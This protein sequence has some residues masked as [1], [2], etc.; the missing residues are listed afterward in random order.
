MLDWIPEDIQKRFGSIAD[1]VHSGDYLY[2]PTEDARGIVQA[3]HT[4]GYR[5]E[6]DE[7]LIER[8]HGMR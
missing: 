3:M 8:A 2:L 6:E 7:E 5:C 1:S 4:H